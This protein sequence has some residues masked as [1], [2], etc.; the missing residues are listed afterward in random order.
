MQRLTKW[1]MKDKIEKNDRFREERQVLELKNVGKDY[2]RA[3]MM[4]RALDQVSLRFGESGMAVLLGDAGSGKSTLL[5]LLAGEEQCSRGEIRW[6]DVSTAAFSES[7]WDDWRCTTVG[8]LSPEEPLLEGERLLTNLE[9]AGD[10]A[11]MGRKSRRSRAA[12]LLKKVGL[13]DSLRRTPAQ[14]TPLQRRRACLALALM[15]DADILLCDEPTAGLD[16]SGTEAVIRLLRAVA[17][18]RLVLV[19]TASES[20]AERCGGRLIRLRHGRI[21]EDSHRGDAGREN[22]GADENHPLRSRAGMSLGMAAALA[23]HRARAEKGHTLLGLLGGCLGVLALSLTL[24]LLVGLSGRTTAAE[25]DALSASPVTVTEEVPTAEELL[26]VIRRAGENTTAAGGTVSVEREEAALRSA[27]VGT[28]DRREILKHFLS[29][30][31]EQGSAGESARSVLRCDWGVEPEVYASDTAALLR[32][33]SGPEAL[34]EGVEDLPL[35]A[36]LPGN[37]ALLE[38]QYD[39][40]AGRWPLSYNEVVLIAD[41]HGGVG[42]LVLR[43]LGLLPE[44]SEAERL[45]YETL[46]AATFKLL[47]PT[48]AFRQGAD[49]LWAWVGGDED[50]LRRAV[51]SAVTIHVVGVVR[52]SAAAA[53]APIKGSV[54]YMPTLT[55]YVCDHSAGSDVIAA[56][57][58]SPETDIFTGLPF[59][60][61]ALDL[62]T[63]A[64]RAIDYADYALSL[65]QPDQ[66]ALC[67]RLTGEQS[68]TGDL[69]DALQKALEGL[70]T[71]QLAELWEESLPLRYSSATLEE[72]LARLGVPDTDHPRALRFYAG[73]FRQQ[74]EITEL[75]DRY[76]RERLAAGAPEELLCYHVETESV[77]RALGAVTESEGRMLRLLLGLEL[78][79]LCAMFYALNRARAL[80]LRPAARALWRLGASPRD[81]SRM[82]H[83]GALLR[84][85]LCGALGVLLGIAVAAA[86]PGELF[87]VAWREELTLALGTAL[88]SLLFSLPAGFRRRELRAER[89]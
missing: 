8:R 77:G 52:P 25:E 46:L 31:E 75:L 87:A 68:I 80:S 13:G 36:E 89:I 20:V 48:D 50:L 18:N 83:S 84:G 61:E 6:G 76:N 4:Q 42:D 82:V 2:G 21:T 32:R 35:W 78:L 44:G 33:V 1:E 19:A 26:T 65:S 88:L 72:N 7:D 64:E 63:P 57:T 73:S 10:L 74:S 39:V 28:E 11:G 12:S 49:G 85:A 34:P 5:R 45:N 16:E 23:L 59:A 70:S 51:E 14:L 15:N 69:A 66:L 41:E 54:G 29:W 43:A 71:A 60:T 67:R 47:L 30:L 79:T 37:M 53:A 9:A 22:A 40:L 81:V 38:R 55:E 27:L 58:A 3:D 56:Q 24:S 17:Q 62:L 86:W